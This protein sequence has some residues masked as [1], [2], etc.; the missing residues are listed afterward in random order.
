VLCFGLYMMGCGKKEET[1]ES[2]ETMSLEALGNIT[3][4]L[5]TAPEAKIIEPKA[6]TKVIEPQPAAKLEPLPPAGP[7]KPSETEI[8]TALKNAGV[9]TGEI[10]GKIGP[11]TKKAIVEFQQANGL[12]ADGK[13]G[14]KTW[15]VLSKYLQPA[16]PAASK[17]R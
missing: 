3:T 8:Q 7:Y 2:Q 17:K 10:D 6:E 4:N 12:E 15:A 14:P 1:M 11:M 9:Y 5:Q 16:T 13:I